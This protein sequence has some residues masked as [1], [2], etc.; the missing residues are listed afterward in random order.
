MVA[1]AA[2]KFQSCYQAVPKQMDPSLCGDFT[3]FQHALYELR[4][5]DDAVITELNELTPTAS[6][7]KGVD[8]AARCVGFND[9]LAAAHSMRTNGINT[10]IAQLSD[11]VLKM[12]EDL[13]IRFCVSLQA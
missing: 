9:R 12:K 1:I 3:E 11:R 5:I 6:F 7:K 4:K 8:V 2:G 13:V 10:C